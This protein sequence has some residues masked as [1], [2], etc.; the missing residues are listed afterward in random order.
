[1]LSNHMGSTLAFQWRSSSIFIAVLLCHLIIFYA[2]V[3]WG[4]KGERQDPMQFIS[5]SMLSPSHAPHH[6]ESQEHS[7]TISGNDMQAAS[8]RRSASRALPA[9]SNSREVPSPDSRASRQA[10]S[11]AQLPADASSSASQGTRHEG[12][13]ASQSSSETSG[14]RFDAGYLRNPKPVYPSASRR[15]GEE[16]KVILR[17]RVSSSGL[18]LTIET[19]QSSGHARLDDAAR[20]AVEKWRFVPAKHGTQPVEAWVLVPLAFSLDSE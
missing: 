20:S 8:N 9:V 17:V 7:S 15:F 14:A 13:V 11:P 6:P 2:A 10:E 5:V 16:G 18:P 4:E 19:R 1:M 12:S 3:G